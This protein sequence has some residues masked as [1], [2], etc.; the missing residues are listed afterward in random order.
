VATVI[1]LVAFGAFAYFA[2]K[3]GSYNKGWG[4]LAAVLVMLTWPWLSAVALPL[5]AEINA[6]AERRPE[7]RDGKRAAVGVHVPAER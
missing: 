4:S 5:G 3:F 1:W 7:P 6:E 2:A